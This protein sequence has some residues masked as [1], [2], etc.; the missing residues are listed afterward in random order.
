MFFLSLRV[1][2]LLSSSLLLF[3]QRFGRYVLRPSSGVCCLNF[4]EETWWFLSLRVFG[5]L[6]SFLLLFPQRIGRYVLQPSSGVC[7]LNFWEEAWWF[8]SLRVSDYCLHLY[9]YFHHVSA[10]MSSGLLQVFVELGNLHGTSNYVFYWIHDCSDS[11]SHNR[12]QVLSIPVL[13][14]ACSQDW[15]CNLQMIVS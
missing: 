9:C 13:L 12:V 6:S 4:W 2:G 5:L 11:V 3:P 1:F 10:D 15:T 7:C 14:I 8:L